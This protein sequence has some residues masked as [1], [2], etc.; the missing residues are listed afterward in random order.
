MATKYTDTITFESATF[1]AI[2]ADLTQAA[3][4]G[5]Y[6]Q[7]GKERKWTKTSNSQG[8]F[9][10]STRGC[11]VA[12]IIQISRVDDN[13]LTDIKVVCNVLKDGGEDIKKRGVLLLENTING[14]LS[15]T[16]GHSEQIVAEVAGQ[17]GKFT[18]TASG[19]KA[20]TTY[21]IRAFAFGQAYLDSSNELAVGY[22]NRVVTATTNTPVELTF[23]NGQTAGAACSECIS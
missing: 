8:S 13:S 9:T 23:C 18:A 1:L 16:N 5:W 12:P 19:L 4:T 21:K 14:D 20:D 22:S 15:Y 10:Y 3:D 11:T 17:T 7:D 6:T 2:D